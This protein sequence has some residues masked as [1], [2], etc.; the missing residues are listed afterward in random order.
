MVLLLLVLLLVVVVVLLLLAVM[1][2]TTK[3]AKMAVASV[4]LPCAVVVTTEMSALGSRLLELERH[5]LRTSS[6]LGE[7][8]PGRGDRIAP[9]L[10]SRFDFA[11]ERLVL[12]RSFSDVGL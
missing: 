6:R 1:R 5:C 11:H 8:V 10:P 3:P 12:L 2:P 7:Q 9:T 4:V